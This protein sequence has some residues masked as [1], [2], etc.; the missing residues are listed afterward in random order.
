[1]EVFQETRNGKDPTEANIR[2]KND[3]YTNPCG[4][5]FFEIMIKLLCTKGYETSIGSSYN[6]IS[7]KWEL[8]QSGLIKAEPEYSETLFW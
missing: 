8:S 6:L 5:T 4:E 2:K 7:V 3:C 1:M